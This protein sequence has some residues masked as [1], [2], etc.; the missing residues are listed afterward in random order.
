ML[1]ADV[2]VL[3]A[4]VEVLIPG[5]E[6]LISGVGVEVLIAGV[7]GVGGV[8]VEVLIPGVDGVD[9]VGVEVLIAGVDGVGVTPS[10]LAVREDRDSLAWDSLDPSTAEGTPAPLTSRLLGPRGVIPSSGTG[11][12]PS[13]V[14]PPRGRASMSAIC[15]G[16]CALGRGVVLST[17]APKGDLSLTAL[18]GELPLELF[19]VGLP[20]CTGEVFRK[21]L[22]ARRNTR[23]AENITPSGS[24]W[25]SCSMHWMK[26]L[27]SSCRPLHTDFETP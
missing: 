8:G 26:Y 18:S 1:I 9:G 11:E 3:I 4:G 19:C 12:D 14:L 15:D 27:S 20:L 10:M 24:L 13:E 7:D 5:V 16:L 21:M 23:N 17:G 25:K 2:E 22:N 6:V